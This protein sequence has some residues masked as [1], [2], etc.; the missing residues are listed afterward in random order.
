LDT[1]QA[2]MVLLFTIVAGYVQRRK[3]ASGKSSPPE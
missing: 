2:T 3:R 1:F